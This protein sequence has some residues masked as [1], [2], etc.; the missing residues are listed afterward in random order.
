MFR[1]AM[2]GN[3]QEH[4]RN[5]DILKETDGEIIVVTMRR[6]RIELFGH[7]KRWN[8]REDM[9]IEGTRAIGRPKLIWQETVINGL[10]TCGVKEEWA[11]GR[12]K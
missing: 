3:L 7:V 10:N 8:E 1:C 5:M 4:R 9:K 11:Q 12:K 2:G 6:R